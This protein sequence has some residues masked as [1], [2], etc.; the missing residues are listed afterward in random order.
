MIVYAQ[1]EIL[2][3]IKEEYTWCK[4]R[5][6]FLLNWKKNTMEKSEGTNKAWQQ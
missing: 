2:Q 3:G 6:E 4:Q 1:V 5:F